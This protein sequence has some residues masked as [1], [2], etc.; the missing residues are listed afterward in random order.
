[1]DNAD[2]L[3]HLL[4]AADNAGL[5]R[6][7]CDMDGITFLASAGIAALLQARAKAETAG[8]RLV[9]SRL[10]PTV[11][12]VLQVT[13]VLDVLISSTPAQHS[14]SPAETRPLPMPLP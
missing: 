13:G 1:M 11:R 14:P 10:R 12:H 7:V 4:A 6:V 2:H 5:G 3:T 8:H 9:L